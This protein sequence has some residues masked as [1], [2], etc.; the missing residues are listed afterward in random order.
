LQRLANVAVE[1]CPE[2]FFRN[3]IHNATRGL[4]LVDRA[5]LA[6]DRRA[7]RDRF[8]FHH[9]GLE[10]GID[11]LGT[12]ALHRNVLNKRIAPEVFDFNLIFTSRKIGEIETPLGVG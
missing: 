12:T 11:S 6:A 5:G 10:G 8:Q 9:R 4:L 1:H 7:N 3:D 2:G